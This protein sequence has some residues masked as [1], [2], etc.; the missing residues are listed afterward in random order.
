MSPGDTVIVRD[1]TYSDYSTYKNSSGVGVFLSR[2]GTADNWITFKSEHKGGAALD[3]QNNIVGYG[4]YFGSNVSYIRIENFQVKGFKW[5]GFFSNFAEGAHH[6]YIY[7]NQIYEIGRWKRPCNKGE[8][9]AFGLTGIFASYENSDW[10]IDSNIFHTIGRIP[11]GCTDF[12]YNHD[13][14]IYILGT[15]NTR[16]INNIFYNN[17]AGWGIA[18][19]KDNL[20]IEIVNNTFVGTNPGRAGHLLVR[21]GKNI[22]IQ[23]NISYQT[24]GYMINPIDGMKGCTNCIIRNNLMNVSTIIQPGYEQYFILSSNVTS[25]DPKFKNPDSN[26]YHL[27]LKSPAVNRGF[28][29]SSPSYDL[30]RNPRPENGRY[31][32]GAYEFR[33]KNSFESSI[34]VNLSSG[35]APLTVQFTSNISG[36]MSPYRY[37]WDFGDG[38]TSVEKNPSHTFTQPGLYSVTLTITDSGNNRSTALQNIVVQS[39]SGNAPSVVDVRFTNVDQAEELTSIIP[40]KWYDLYYYVNDPQGWQD[41]SYADVWLNHESNNEGNLSNRGGRFF[42]LSNYIMSYSISTYEIWARE[43]EET[44]DWTNISGKAGLYVDDDNGEYQQNGNEMWAKARIK[45]LD[46]ALTGNWLINAYVID[47]TRNVSTLYQKHIEVQSADAAPTASIRLSDPSPTKGGIIEVTLSCSR[48][49]VNVPNPLILTESD[50][51]LTTIKLNGQVPGA[52]FMGQLLIDNTVA[53]GWSQFS[54]PDE[55]LVAE[56][57]V[58]GNQITRGSV[59][60]IDKTS[61][62]KPRLIRAKFDLN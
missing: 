14:G 28:N 23:N 38:N 34:K 45:L 20:N 42:A 4:W 40:G 22:L 2:S 13:H 27:Q 6:I 36:G 50:N 60:M 53:E 9:V 52:V 24:E 55:A 32:I 3:G 41:I 35:V 54:L 57:G 51:T 37:T 39:I 62:S 46:S 58:K 25:T 59:I 19:H 11:S 43:R 5:H 33:V 8:Y 7:G 47:K 49:L 31:D 17:Q 26:N 1:G 21:E 61:P 29:A 30:D 10:T 48:N 44:A 18:I 15:K 12:D 56:N 16:I